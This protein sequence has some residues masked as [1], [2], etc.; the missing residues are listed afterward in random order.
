M[1]T[2]LQVVVQYEANAFEG[3]GTALAHRH[4]SDVISSLP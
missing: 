2:L 4:S 3:L 1:L